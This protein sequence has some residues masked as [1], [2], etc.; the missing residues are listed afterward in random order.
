MVFQDL[1]EEIV[2]FLAKYLNGK[3]IVAL[4]HTCQRFFYI[5]N[6]DHLWS[7][8][9][10][11]EKQGKDADIGHISKV[12]AQEAKKQLGAFPNVAKEKFSYM[13][14]ERISQNWKN[15]R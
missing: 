8:V 13:H 14:H 12:L 11:R 4:S 3:E 5:L 15:C 10:E 7:S 6:S 1:P 2:L 9:S